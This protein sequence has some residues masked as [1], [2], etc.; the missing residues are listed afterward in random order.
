M[1]RVPGS[2]G[3][4]ACLGLD[5]WPNQQVSQRCKSLTWNRFFSSS[6]TQLKLG[7]L[8][9]SKTWSPCDL[10]GCID[11]ESVQK[12][13]QF[14][15][16]GFVHQQFHWEK[17]RYGSLS[18]RMVCCSGNVQ[19]KSSVCQTL[20]CHRYRFHNQFFKAHMLSAFAMWWPVAYGRLPQH[21]D[22]QLWVTFDCLSTSHTIWA[23]LTEGQCQLWKYY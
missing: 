23:D 13:E 5:L 14:K 21:M 16:G 12:A 2:S 22:E 18:C 1:E 11:L 6:M 3:A 20:Q 9:P 19:M 4:W 8:G 17:Q 10:V 7:D 15:E